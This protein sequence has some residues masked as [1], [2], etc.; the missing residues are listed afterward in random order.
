V[1]CE[2][3]LQDDRAARY[4]AGEL[5]EADRDA[6]EVHV[7]ECTA[8]RVALDAHL[9]L[10]DALRRGAHRHASRRPA[11]TWLPLA[12]T[13]AVAALAG[14]VVLRDR[15][16][17]TPGPGGPASPVATAPSPSPP[18]GPPLDRPDVVL[19]AGEVLV[20]RGANDSAFLKDFGPAIAPYRDGNPALAAERLAALAP[21][22]PASFEVGF[23]EGVS[24][25]L[26]GRAGAAVE[27]L[28]RARSLGR[29]A[30]REDAEWYLAVALWR[31][32]RPEDAAAGLRTLCSGEGARKAAACA[33]LPGAPAGGG[34]AP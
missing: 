19:P 16:T 27:P 29:G 34:R 21:R 30:Q 32:G 9:D 3:A 26:A 10:A 31:A 4:V 2:S 18:P 33:A 14:T 8:C 22:Y 15:W 23:Y 7:L 11:R 13:L 28:E 1:A 5:R 25:L 20:T 24:L 12:A 17:T 6:F